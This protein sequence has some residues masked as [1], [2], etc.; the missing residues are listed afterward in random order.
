MPGCWD[1]ITTGTNRSANKMNRFSIRCLKYPFEVDEAIS[2]HI[3]QRELHDPGIER[4]SDLA[5][6]VAVARGSKSAGAEAVQDVIG[7]RTEF[8]VLVFAQSELP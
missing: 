5:E 8:N 1:C 6:R 3:L 2:E 4:R 7:F